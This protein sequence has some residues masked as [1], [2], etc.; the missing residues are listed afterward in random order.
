MS[1]RRARTSTLRIKHHTRRR[2]VWVRH[3]SFVLGGARESGR[4]TREGTKKTKPPG[5]LTVQCGNRRNAHHD[6]KVL[7]LR[8]FS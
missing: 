6:T 2:S 4:G 3:L 7:R 8:D 1:T 5:E